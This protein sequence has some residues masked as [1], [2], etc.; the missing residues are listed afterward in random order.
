MSASGTSD[1]I[2]P[3]LLDR[4]SHDN[5]VLVLPHPHHRPLRLVEPSGVPPVP[6]DI[7]L[8]LASPPLSV[9]LGRDGMLWAAMPEAPIHKDGDTGPGKHDVRTPGEARHV[10]PVPKTAPVQLMSDREFRSRSRRTEVRHEPAYGGTR[11]HRLV[12]AR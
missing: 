8:Q 11:R 3:E 12:G 1:P 9:G 10:H 2:P 7:R 4:V 6:S 5:G